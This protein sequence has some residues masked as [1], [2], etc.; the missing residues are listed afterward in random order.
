[1]SA[2]SLEERQVEMRARM[3]TQQ[4]AVATEPVVIASSRPRVTMSLTREQLYAQV[5]AEPMTTVAAQ[6][7]VSSNYLARVCRSLRVPHPPRGHWAKL[8]VGEVGNRPPLPAARP[9]QLLV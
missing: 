1:M 5:W 9:G 4:H 6:Y 7:H 2:K 8:R 3:A